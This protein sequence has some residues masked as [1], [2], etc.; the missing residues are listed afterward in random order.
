MRSEQELFQNFRGSLAPEIQEDIDR[1][2]FVYDMYLDEEDAASRERLRGELKLLES[3]Y[4]L[5][6]THK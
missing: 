4:N 2:L 3:K 6:V 1:Y 5:E